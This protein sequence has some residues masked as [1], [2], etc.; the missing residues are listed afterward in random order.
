MP[1]PEGDPELLRTANIRS[2]L[3]LAIM[4]MIKNLFRRAVMMM[5]TVYDEIPATV[6]QNVG[7]G[8]QCNYSPGGSVYSRTHRRNAM[9]R[10][11]LLKLTSLPYTTCLLKSV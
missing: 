1:C 2:V 3:N 4:R 8:G 10:C 7:G 9:A 5:I 11:A 6:L